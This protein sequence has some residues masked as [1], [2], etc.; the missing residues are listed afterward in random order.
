VPEGICGPCIEEKGP[1]GKI[2]KRRMIYSSFA[3]NRLLNRTE[4]NYLNQVYQSCEGDS[5]RAQAWTRGDWSVISGGI[6]DEIFYKYANTIKE[7]SFD[8]PDSGRYFFAYDHGSTEP[9]CFLAAWENT[10][11]QDVLFHDGKVRSGRRGDIHIIGELYISTGKPNEGTNDPIAE[12]TRKWTEYKILR[13]WRWRDPVTGK[14]RDIMKKGCADTNIFDVLNERCIA[15]EFEQPITVAGELH[16]GI[17][18]ERADKGPN[19][20]ATGVALMRERFI[21]TAPG[22][23]SGVREKPGLFVVAE[24]CPNFLRTVPV[25]ARD[26]RDQNKYPEDGENHCA[27]TCRYLLRFDTG[28]AFSTR[29]RQVF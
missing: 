27:D 24:E 28:P 3:D 26:K 5:A 1:D 12:I 19:S 10:D 20:V 22:K 2:S 13:G 11:G 9:A 16:P 7:P 17:R 21:G 4:P 29:R 18:F 25:L 6:F 8:P 23:E 15:T 14:W